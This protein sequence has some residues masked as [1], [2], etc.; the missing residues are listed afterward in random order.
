MGLSLAGSTTQ[1]DQSGG[2]RK[3]LDWPIAKYKTGSPEGELCEQKHRLPASAPDPTRKRHCALASDPACL[4]ILDSAFW[5]LTDSDFPV[6][7]S[8]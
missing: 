3:L 7:D 4:L 8:D 1:Q 2:L 6:P 5:P